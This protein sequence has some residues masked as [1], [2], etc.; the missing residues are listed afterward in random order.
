MNKH[1]GTNWKQDFLTRNIDQQSTIGNMYLNGKV[2]YNTHEP[3]TDKETINRLKEIKKSRIV[4]RSNVA[5]DDLFR[6]RIRCYI[7]NSRL[8]LNAH[9]RKKRY[10]YNYHCTKCNKKKRERIK[11]KKT[12]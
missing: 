12:T 5:H 2:F 11:V 9:K 4:R 7:C 1:Y 10:Y 6:L 8:S 3:L